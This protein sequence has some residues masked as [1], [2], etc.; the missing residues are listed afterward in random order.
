MP[1]RMVYRSD[2]FDPDHRG[3]AVDPEAS[4][5]SVIGLQG[6]VESGC[7]ICPQPDPWREGWFTRT[8]EY[9]G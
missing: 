4:R 6:L 3:A 5:R 9:F 2:P 8:P 1:L 7:P